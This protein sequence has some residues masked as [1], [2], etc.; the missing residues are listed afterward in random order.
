MVHKIH[1]FYVSVV[2]ETNGQI[3]K[4]IRESE[5]IKGMVCIFVDLL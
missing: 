2:R 4:N 1:V 3:Q 5:T